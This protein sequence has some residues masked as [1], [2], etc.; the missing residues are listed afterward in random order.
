MNRLRFLQLLAALPFCGRLAG[1][2]AQ[3][4]LMLG[5]K[6]LGGGLT[7]EKLIAAKKLLNSDDDAIYRPGT[8]SLGNITQ[9]V[10][11]R[12]SLCHTHEVTTT[13]EM[14]DGT[15]LFHI[16]LYDEVP[17]IE[18]LE[19]ERKRCFTGVVKREAQ[20]A[21]WQRKAKAASARRTQA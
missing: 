5:G 7:L 4:P 8:E 14:K 13:A 6:P 18:Q 12:P 17:T 3:P 11:Y 1:K 10:S 2:P 21:R 9:K 19:F 16:S 20:L 15:L